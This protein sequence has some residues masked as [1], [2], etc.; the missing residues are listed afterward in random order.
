MVVDL[1]KMLS[2]TRLGSKVG[3]MLFF[4]LPS[5]ASMD[6]VKTSQGF[7]QQGKT[8]CWKGFRS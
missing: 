3:E 6:V 2:C 4:F 5:L 7:Q 1:V 8:Q